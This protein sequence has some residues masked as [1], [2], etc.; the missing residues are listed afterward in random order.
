M[1]FILLLVIYYLFFKHNVYLFFRGKKP[2]D[3]KYYYP[4]DFYFIK[5]NIIFYKIISLQAKF[6]IINSS[7]SVQLLVR[8]GILVF[9]SKLFYKKTLFFIHGIEKIVSNYLEIYSSLNL[10]FK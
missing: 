6:V 8:D 2:K 1:V 3:K 4:K 7:L 9:I 10:L 5:S